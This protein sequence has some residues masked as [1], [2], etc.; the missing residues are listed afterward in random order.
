MGGGTIPMGSASPR[1]FFTVSPARRGVAFLILSPGRR[2][3]GAEKATACGSRRRPIVVPGPSWRKILV[4]HNRFSPGTKNPGDEGTHSVAAL[5]ERRA[6]KR[7]GNDAPWKA[8]NTQKA[9]FPLFPPGL[10]NPAKNQ[11]DFPHC[12]KPLR[13]S[14]NLAF[15]VEPAGSCQATV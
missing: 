13:G 1:T 12:T 4:R 10:E 9:S 2:A 6:P 11:P 3:R 15:C 5:R 14:C 7:R 8:W